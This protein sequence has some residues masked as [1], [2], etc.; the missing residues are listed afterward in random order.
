MSSWFA[1]FL[2]IIWFAW[3]SCLVAAIE[4]EESTSEDGSFRTLADFTN[5]HS[6]GLART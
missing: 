2:T 6:E 1:L 3:V 4:L 5:R